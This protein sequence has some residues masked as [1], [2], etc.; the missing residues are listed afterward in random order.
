VGA[1]GTD[2][3]ASVNPQN[4]ADMYC[5]TDMGETWHTT[6]G[7][8]NWTTLGYNSLYS[9][10]EENFVQFTGN[11]N[12]Q[13][14]INNHNKEPMVTTD[15]GQTWTELAGYPN[16]QANFYSPLSIEA[17]PNDPTGGRIIL[18]MMDGDT[19]KSNTF[20]YKYYF[21]SVG[22]ADWTTSTVPFSSDTSNTNLNETWDAGTF[23]DTQLPGH[24]TAYFAT[25]LGLWE[26]S[27]VTSA[28]PTWTQY[29]LPNNSGVDAFYSFTGSATTSGTRLWAVTWDST[30]TN[31]Q[32]SPSP[33]GGGI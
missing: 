25:D 22:G 3:H 14:G 23:W 31:F 11:T 32:G 27:N 9:E 28:T 13:Y 20:D 8:L 19:G 12:I 18:V 15:D 17:D 16:I 4:P 7:G 29:D 24:T 21:S 10:G 5:E 30:G 26:S 1:G 6:N 33:T 2:Y